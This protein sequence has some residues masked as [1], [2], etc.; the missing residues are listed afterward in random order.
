MQSLTHTHSPQFCLKAAKLLMS[1]Q[2]GL[3]P[4]VSWCFCLLQLC[5]MDRVMT[6]SSFC[7]FRQDKHAHTHKYK[8]ANVLHITYW[9]SHT[10]TVHLVRCTHGCD[11]CENVLPHDVPTATVD[12][13]VFFF[14]VCGSVCVCVCMCAMLKC[15]YSGVCPLLFLLLS[16]RVFI[17]CV[18]D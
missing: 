17:V 7:F 15:A 6:F 8:S 14:G 5:V 1:S 10:H 3:S 11:T 4:N 2:W 13:S 9:F 18:S 16:Q 12:G